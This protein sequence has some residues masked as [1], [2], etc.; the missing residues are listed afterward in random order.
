MSFLHV[1]IGPSRVL[2]YGCPYEESGCTFPRVAS[3]RN[4]AKARLRNHINAHMNER[5]HKS[6]ECDRDYRRESDLERHVTISHLR[7]L[8]K[9]KSRSHDRPKN[10]SRPGNAFLIFRSELCQLFE[11]DGRRPENISKLADE[12]WQARSSEEKQIYVDKAEEEM[13]KYKTARSYP[14][15][16]QETER[17]VQ[18]RDL[19]RDNLGA[20]S[21]VNQHFGQESQAGYQFQHMQDPGIYNVFPS[22]LGRP[23][24]SETDPY[25]ASAPS[26]YQFAPF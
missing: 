17:S 15:T 4:D 18:G 14:F 6:S 3:A 24:R 11:G 2:F 20:S 1:L 25:H 21:G 22:P 8:P 13:R 5:P 9:K 7:T 16:N 10:A 26:S 23:V 12:L 19:A